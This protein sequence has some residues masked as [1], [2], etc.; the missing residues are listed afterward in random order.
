[1]RRMYGRVSAVDT[2]QHIF[3]VSFVDGTDNRC[4][5]L[6]DLVSLQHS[7]RLQWIQLADI[8]STALDAMIK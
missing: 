2:E 6:A 7:E 5:N 1:M 8:I 3:E 4:Y